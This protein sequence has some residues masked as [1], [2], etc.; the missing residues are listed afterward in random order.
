MLSRIF[1]VL[2]LAAGLALADE[3]SIETAERAWASGVT[4]KNYPVLEKVL[5]NDLIYSHSNGLVDTKKSYIDALKT[6]KA[7]YYQINYESIRVKMLDANTAMAFCR[8]FF[9]TK[10]ADGSKQEMVLAFLHVFRKN[11][12]DWQLVGHQSARMPAK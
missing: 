3:K 11:G 2:T 5:A 8:A 12:N 1:L 6:G 10:A 7:E 9:Q 4:G